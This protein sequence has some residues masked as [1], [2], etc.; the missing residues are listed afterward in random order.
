[1]NEWIDVAQLKER[2][3][4]KEK[5]KKKRNSR[6]VKHRGGYIHILQRR[7][8]NGAPTFLQNAM[9]PS[10][11]EPSFLSSFYDGSEEE[12][13]GAKQQGTAAEKRK[14][15]RTNFGLFGLF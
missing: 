13:A 12:A 8:D 1:M 14:G 3:I 2:L 9:D 11:P 6:R 15:K 5:K 10:E 7:G 4:T